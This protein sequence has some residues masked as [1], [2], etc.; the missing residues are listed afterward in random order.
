MAVY[1]LVKT[2]IKNGIPTE[3]K[4][5]V[6]VYPLSHGQVTVK[7]E[8]V[9]STASGKGFFIASSGDG[10]VKINGVEYPF[11]YEKPFLDS[12]TKEK[13]L[14]SITSNPIELQCIDNQKQKIDISMR[15]D[16]KINYFE[17]E[18]DILATVSSSYL[19][20]N[21]CSISV[22][23]VYKSTTVAVSGTTITEESTIDLVN[24]RTHDGAT[25]SLSYTC[26]DITEE[27]FT[28]ESGDYLTFT[29][30]DTLAKQN[31]NGTELSVTFT[32]T[33]HFP[34]GVSGSKSSTVS[35]SIPDKDIFRPKCTV[36]VTDGEH[37]DNVPLVDRYGGF[38]LGESRFKIKVTPILA[39]DS[40]VLTCTIKANDETYVGYLEAETSL[41]KHTGVNDIVV[42]LTDNRGRSCEVSTTANVLDYHKPI[43]DI[44]SLDRC[45]R[46]GVDDADGD[47]L[48]VTFNV[49]VTPLNDIN[50][51]IYTLNYQASSGMHQGQDNLTNYIGQY[52]VDGGSYIFKADSGNTYSVTLTVD[53]D[54]GNGFDHEGADESTTIWN[55]LASGD[56]FAFGTVASLAGVLETMFKVFPRNGFMFPKFEGSTLFDVHIIPNV[57]T[58]KSGKDIAKSPFEGEY[59][60]I[61]LPGG[62]VGDLLYIAISKE[63]E[64]KINIMADGSWVNTW[65]TLTV[66]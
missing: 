30:P 65:K 48:K 2:F 6:T 32:L 31:P 3:S 7:C 62:G 34:F 11:T 59:T 50:S 28:K 58:V 18:D 22:D 39:Y 40:E 60:L 13:K 16:G 54:L 42:T 63:L 26:G 53:D 37:L 19:T 45:D 8:V 43:V 24:K 52:S 36:E 38:I 10:Y 5:K 47:H 56:G 55:A 25:H 20:M 4:L 9:H 35:F 41:L 57:Y 21:D 61:V 1:N 23:A 14:G 27:L 66:T 17:N 29:L 12:K 33:T 49:K 15:F 46:N 51:A 64:V 44:T